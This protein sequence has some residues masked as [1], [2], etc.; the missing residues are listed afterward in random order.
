MNLIK[1]ALRF[2]KYPLK[3]RVVSAQPLIFQFDPYNVMFGEIFQGKLLLIVN[4]FIQNNDHEIF[5]RYDM[6]FPFPV[7]LYK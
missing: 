1:L 6:C 5:F 7:F 3:D 2:L 4:I